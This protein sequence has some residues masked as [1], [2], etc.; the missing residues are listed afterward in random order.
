MTA[1]EVLKQYFGYSEFRPGQREIIE[2]LLSERDVLGIMPTGA[3]K[4]LCYQIPA[5][6]LDGVTLVVS[7]LI[8][9]M[10]DQVNALTQTGVSAAFINSSLPYPEYME[11]IRRAKS[12]EYKII[13][14][15]P[16]RLMR[17][18][19]LE[20]AAT[21]PVAMLT[22]DE[23]HCVS[24]WG[25]DF[26]PSYRKIVDFIDRLP[27]KP[28]I[29][30]FTATA[31]AK[32]RD[33][34]IS[35]LALDKPHALTTGFDRQNLYFEVQRPKDKMTSLVNYLKKNTGKSGIVYCATRKAVEEV[36]KTLNDS[37]FEAT[38]YHAGLSDNERRK[39]Q[40]DFLYD[41][42]TV[43]AATNAFGMGIDKSNVAFVI[44]YNMPKNIESYYQ[45]AGRAGRDG[46]NADCILFYSGQD[47]NINKYLIEHGNESPMKQ[48]ESSTDEQ[49]SPALLAEIKR[50]NL[51]L[52]K[53]MTF[54]STT[55]DCLRAFILRYFGEIAPRYCGRCSNCLT[56]FEKSDITV[57][58]QKIV[59]CVYRIE[60]HG[61]KEHTVRAFG[62]AMIAD[63]LHGSKNAKLHEAKLDTLSTYG[64]MAG[65]SI[66]RI[67]TI[68]DSLLERGYLAEG[69]YQ[70]IR[71]TEKSR[72][73]LTPDARIEM[74]LPRD[75]MQSAV[76]E[77]YHITEN[78]DIDDA[79]VSR[80]KLLRNR[81]A[82]DARVPSY[83]VFSDATIRELCRKR[84]ETPEQF[85]AV[86]GVGQAKLEKY[87][88]IFMREI[89]TY[90]KTNQ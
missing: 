58:A 22:V 16:E 85:L 23:A 10:K 40:D 60:Q 76:R 70:T 73:A 50:N 15:A 12:G 74:M 77:K 11:T 89:G 65:T 3:G 26:R 90:E 68:L 31:T 1:I 46:E 79:L 7:P 54:Y 66:R 51:E 67:R 18:E 2:A 21:V 19:M 69:E 56:Q 20:L 72:E 57:E 29:G 59:S 48:S 80:L 88:A 84:P 81:L 24:Q 8:S 45:E 61:A 37:G 32:V 62:K 4:S 49:L 83:I 36:H 71:R 44:H 52:L 17:D 47:V 75:E 39:N 87:G 9:L 13:Y 25:H 34:I 63:I 38:R 33:D 28:V 6:M 86:S 53:Q 35:I 30:A 43:M 42:K 5:L 82:K 14:I 41:K 27:K 78:A 55:T 64:I